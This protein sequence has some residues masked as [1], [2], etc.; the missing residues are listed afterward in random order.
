MHDLPD[1]HPRD[2]ASGGL[3]QAAEAEPHVT[4]EVFVIEHAD[5]VLRP[6]LRIVNR[7]TRMLSFDHA[8]QGVIEREI[9]GQRENVR[10]RHHNRAHAHAV[11]FDGV[12]D[13]LFLKFGNLAEL[14]TG[15]NDELEFVG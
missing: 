5:D 15:G 10:P 2:A 11:E 1:L 6:T 14:A 12:V 9:G 3:A 4:H 7:D 8:D 13:H